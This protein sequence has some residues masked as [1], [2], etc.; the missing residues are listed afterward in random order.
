MKYKTLITLT[1]IYLLY[2]FLWVNP[3]HLN[4]IL[5]PVILLAY[6]AYEDGPDKVF[7][8]FGT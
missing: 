4:F 8:N 2:S 5:V 6:A 1:C 7:R 3:R